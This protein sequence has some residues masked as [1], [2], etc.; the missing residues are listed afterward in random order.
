MLY[1]SYSEIWWDLLKDYIVFSSE[2]IVMCLL[3]F[4]VS[5]M[6][7]LF[8][9]ERRSRWP[10]R[11]Q[12]SWLRT[13]SASS[14]SLRT[15]RLSGTPPPACP[16]ATEW[17]HWLSSPTSLWTRQPATRSKT[18]WGAKTSASWW[19]VWTSRSLPPRAWLKSLSRACWTRWIRM[20]RWRLWWPG[21]CCRGW[22]SAAEGLWS[23]YHRGPAADLCLDEWH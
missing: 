2:V 19:P 18:P 7:P 21:W 1:S 8:S 10:E 15:R 12:R 17:R 20:W 5:L 13:V 23:I 14:S 11:T 22:W 3:L 16:R 9:Q 6:N 4:T